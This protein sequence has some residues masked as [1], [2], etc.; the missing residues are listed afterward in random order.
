MG[1]NTIFKPQIRYVYYQQQTFQPNNSTNIPTKQIDKIQ[2]HVTRE[3]LPKL[4]YNRNTPIA[5]AYITPTFDDI[6]IMHLPS[7]Q[8]LL[9]ITAI[10]SRIKSKT[11]HSDPIKLIL[12]S[13]VFYAR[14]H[15]STTHRYTTSTLRKGAMAT[16]HSGISKTTQRNNH[17][18]I[19]Q[20]SHKIRENDIHFMEHF[21]QDTS[22]TRTELSSINSIRLHLKVTIL[23][24]ICNTTGKNILATMN[25]TLNKSESIASIPKSKNQW[26]R[27]PKSTLQAIRLW[28]KGVQTRL[29]KS[30]SQTTLRTPLGNWKP[31][32]FHQR[33]WKFIRYKDNTLKQDWIHPTATTK[34]RTTQRYHSTTTHQQEVDLSKSTPLIPTHITLNMIKTFIFQAQTRIP[35]VIPIITCIPNLIDRPNS[36]KNTHTINWDLYHLPQS[37]HFHTFRDIQRHQQRNFH[38]QQPPNTIDD[39]RASAINVTR[40]LQTCIFILQQLDSSL[41]PIDYKYHINYK[42]QQPHLRHTCRTNTKSLDT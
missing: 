25:V 4:D 17:H 13:Y 5:I 42:Q 14:T 20:H 21:H 27:Q 29:I 3:I 32:C 26:P 35:T 6:R 1:H 24:E 28:K 18:T 7:P 8:G 22:L 19:Y 23:A 2:Q 39:Y 41:P 33:N 30:G 36:I 40:A 31:T 38:Q 16:V 9:H 10:L 37:T 34:T 11:T 15:T 12:E